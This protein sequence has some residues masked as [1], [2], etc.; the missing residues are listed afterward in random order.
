MLGA[1][2]GTPRY[3]DLVEAHF[4]SFGDSA[5][6]ISRHDR[7][8]VVLNVQL[9]QKSLWALPMELVGDVG[10]VESLFRSIWRHY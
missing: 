9:A 4:N 1:L 3:V 10:Q 6:D 7:C 8:M 5:N 2:D